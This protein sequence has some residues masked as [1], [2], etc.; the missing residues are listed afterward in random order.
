[1]SEKA[2]SSARGECVLELRNFV[3]RGKFSDISFKLHRGEVLGI[4]GQPGSGRT[5]LARSIFGFDAIDGGDMLFGGVE[6]RRPGIDVS[7][8]NGIGFIAEV[9]RKPPRPEGSGVIYDLTTRLLKF[10]EAFD[11]V[12]D[13]IGDAT[14][15]LSKA[16]SFGRHSDRNVD[17][18]P[19]AGKI[20]LLAENGMNVI[21]LEEPTRALDEEEK[22]DIR[23][24]L[25][26][27]AEDGLGIIFMSSDSSEAAVVCTRVLVMTDGRITAEFASGTPAEEIAKAAGA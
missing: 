18:L 8:R 24:V 2:S 3:R 9:K 22:G 5:E 13:G 27:L 16:F 23:G 14:A 15:G 17:K 6:V 11:R 20:K 26:R 7:L 25:S 21:I 10:A 19:L 1:M 4:V 12:C